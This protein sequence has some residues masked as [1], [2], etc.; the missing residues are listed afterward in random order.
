MRS[1]HH[2]RQNENGRLLPSSGITPFYP[3]CWDAMGKTLCWEELKLM[4]LGYFPW[5]SAPWLHWHSTREATGNRSA[6]LLLIPGPWGR[7]GLSF[8]HW[9]LH[10]TAGGVRDSKETFAQHPPS[11]PERGGARKALP[12]APSRSSSAPSEGWANSLPRGFAASSSMASSF[13]QLL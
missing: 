11:S 7:A 2:W 10:T 6:W 3:K 13:Y 9:G 4:V 1:C 12:R 5:N 8:R